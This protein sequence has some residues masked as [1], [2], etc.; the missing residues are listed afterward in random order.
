MLKTDLWFCVYL[1]MFQNIYPQILFDLN[2]T[3]NVMIRS[4]KYFFSDPIIQGHSKTLFQSD[5][6]FINPGIYL[7]N[8]LF[9]KYTW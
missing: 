1:L 6:V 7:L 2:K 8:F 3:K 4:M 5:L 9:C